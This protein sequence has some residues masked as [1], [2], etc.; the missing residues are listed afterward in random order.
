MGSERLPGKTLTTVAGRPLLGY[1]LDRL[2]ACRSVREVV[3]ATSNQP[4]DDAVAEFCAA[5]ALRCVRGS[6]LDVAGRFTAVLAECPAEAFVRISGDSPLLDATV[7]ERG[8]ALFAHGD[9]DVVTNVMP[10]SYPPGQSVEVVSS[11]CF[12]EAYPRM[13]AEDEL[14]HVTRYFYK[15]PDQFRILNF[16]APVDYSGISLTIDTAEQLETFRRVVARM[17]R[18]PQDHSLDEVVGL[19]REVDTARE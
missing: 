1:L 11:S 3:V 13:A 16:S 6:H 18:A 14:E 10:R 5:R 2:Q 8:V 17:K 7:V 12:L 4:A 9:W 15:H 19:Y